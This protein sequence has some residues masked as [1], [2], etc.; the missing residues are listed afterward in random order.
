MEQNNSPDVKRYLGVDI[1][2]T[3]YVED[4]EKFK[5]NIEAFKN[6][7][8]KNIVPFFCTGRVRLSAMKVVGDDFQGET[9]YNGYPGVY[10]NGA[11][12]YDSD[13][14]IISHS[15]FSEEFLRKFVKYIIDNNLDDIT[16]FK[17]ADKFFIIKD[18]REEFKSYPKSKNMDNLILIT[19]EEIVKEKVLGIL[20]SNNANLDD[21]PSKLSCKMCTND[22]TYQIS[23]EN[24]TK[25]YGVERL[26][27][28]LG[29]SPDQCSFI[30]DGDNDIE[31]LKYCKLSYAVGNANNAV[32]M[33]A[34]TVL[35]ESYD[36]G[37]FEKA[38]QLV[39]S[40]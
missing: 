11:L 13:G 7:K 24:V 12:V 40:S 29:V 33:A 9:G 15:H 16:I 3:F 27:N 25:A 19:P 4:P 30:G 5:N 39:S 36:Q 32:K 28:Y 10:A 31:V 2:G 14:N 34:K 26:L 23:S 17:G 6:L 35:N 18:L 8:S 1:D 21:L 22:R 20:L 37:A 38:V